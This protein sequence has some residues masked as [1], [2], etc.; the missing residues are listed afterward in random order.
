MN[1][2]PLEEVTPERIAFYLAKRVTGTNLL[3]D[4]TC[5]LGGNLIQFSKECDFVIG[6][7]ISRK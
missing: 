4:L 1:K 2:F 6:I 3:V 7:D 5:G